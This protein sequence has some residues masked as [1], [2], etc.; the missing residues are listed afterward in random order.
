M[1]FRS[2]AADRYYASHGGKTVFLGRFI[3]VVRS[4][5][6]IL[7]GAAGLP[8]RRFIVYDVAGAAIWATG[9]TVLGYLIGAS[10]ERWEKYLTPF[11]L[12]ILVVLAGLIGLTK[13]RAARRTAR[14]A[15]GER[16]DEHRP[17]P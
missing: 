14:E 12:L 15:V 1:L 16:P 4:V 7:A 8:W 11:G 13:V 6:F 9:H 3:P 17:I 10:Y 2:A 5:G